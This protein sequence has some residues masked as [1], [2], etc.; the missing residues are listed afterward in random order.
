MSA[1]SRRGASGLAGILPVDKP[2]GMTS[3]DVVGDVRRATGERRV[4]HAGTL[5]PA[6]TGL[7][8]VLV[9]PAARLAPYLT[10]ESKTYRAVVAFGEET[11]T[12]DAEG[13][14]VARA[15]VPRAVLD[16]T[17]AAL[18]VA[19]LRGARLQAPPAYSAIKVD[20]RKACDAAR[21][22][23]P[24][25][26]EPRPIE[27]AEAVLEAV[28][29]GPPP[30][31]TLTLTVSKG[32]YIRSIARDLGPALGTRAHLLG[33]RRLAAGRLTLDDAVPLSAVAQA[34]K[35]G[36]DAVRALF[37][38]PLAAL[39][40]PVLELTGH[41]AALVRDGCPL[42]MPQPF[43]DLAEGA[44]VSMA[45]GSALRAVYARELGFLVPETVL[46]VPAEPGR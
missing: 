5:D 15:P 26:L 34:G 12:C 13:Q 17:A 28:D 45:E 41:Q 27:V 22:G 8:V 1:V 39:G 37:A 35:A 11:D 38:D 25:D 19:D 43:L 4:G 2:S 40:L 10:A 46:A 21:S 29:P 20:G 36:A 24:I 33:L 16:E 44:L 31:W 6:A 3:H 14:V 18:T 30:T 32:T 23:A 7:L 9:G 42:P